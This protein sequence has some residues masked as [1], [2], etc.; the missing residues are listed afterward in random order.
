MNRRT[1]PRVKP[2]LPVT[3]AL[4]EPGQNETFGL[5]ADISKRGACVLT[6]AKLTIGATVR[7]ALNFPRKL[8]P[9]GIDTKIAPGDAGAPAI[10]GP[11][12]RP[13]VKKDE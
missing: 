4:V 12:R 7:C 3:L 11:N 5:I 6:F 1:V 2:R 9:L 8:E 13:S 10:A